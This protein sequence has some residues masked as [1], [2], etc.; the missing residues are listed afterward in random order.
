M[1][2]L[3]LLFYY[4]PREVGRYREVVNSYNQFT[5]YIQA[6]NGIKDVY[7]SIYDLQFRM[8]KIVF[9]V[10]APSLEKAFDDVK[11]LIT[12]LND[13]DIPYIPVFS[14]GKGFHIYCLFKVWNTNF[15]MLKFIHKQ[16]C[17]QLSNGL[18]Y[19]DK[20]LFGNLRALIRV[21]NTLRVKYSVYCTFLPYDFTRWTTTQIIDYARTPHQ[22]HYHLSEPPDIRMVFDVDFIGFKYGDVEL[23]GTFPTHPVP[24]NVYMFLKPL[25]RPCLY[26]VLLV[27]KNP[28]HLLR[29]ELVAELMWL[30]YDE[31]TIF[32]II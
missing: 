25:I 16:I 28:L 12:T 6:N 31:E 4:Y 18:K 26:R 3:H 2:Y 7:A 8:D 22:P 20:H 30:G 19:V 1:D 14:G 17:L 32:N 13:Y 5:K 15:E 29:V 11:K 21:P 23:P 9:D 24:S 10:D 27:D